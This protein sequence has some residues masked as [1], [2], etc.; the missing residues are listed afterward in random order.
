MLKYFFNNYE[1]FKESF[2]LRTPGVKSSRQNKVLLAFL[3]AKKLQDYLK[4]HNRGLYKWYFEV[5]CMSDLIEFLDHITQ[6][7]YCPY[8]NYMELH[9]KK[10]FNPLYATDENLGITYDGDSESIRYINLETNKPFK[11]RASKMYTRLIEASTVA[12]YLPDA[13][14]NWYSDYL[15]SGWVA[16]ALGKSTFE[17]YVDN[18]FSDI[19]D[20][21]CCEGNFGSCMTDHDQ[22]HFYRDAVDASAAYLKNGE[23]MIIARAIIFNKAIQKGT[24]QSFRL[25]E[26]QYSSDGKEHLKLLLVNKL[27]EG[28]HIDAYKAVGA[29]CHSPRNYISVATGERMEKPYFS[30][31]CKLQ[32]GDTISYQDSFKWFSYGEQRAYNWDEDCARTDLATTSSSVSIEGDCWDSWYEQYCDETTTAYRDGRSYEVNSDRINDDFIWIEYWHRDNVSRCE[33]CEEY[34]VDYLG[35]SDEVFSDVL[36]ESFCS[37]NC[38]YKAELRYFRSNPEELVEY[39]EWVENHIIGFSKMEEEFAEYI[40]EFM[41]Q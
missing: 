30:I 7:A 35:S 2:P 6:P 37:D 19:Y 41:P 23:D 14:K 12:Q 32:D 9:G 17:L 39:T 28:G 38:C 21:D 4:E 15:K 22:W 18:N 27:I 36:G 33:E 8:P 3:K 10:W 25:C 26:R 5:S 20:A 1:G 13:V 16:Y 29:D 11:M 31:K 24:G 40:S 34:Y